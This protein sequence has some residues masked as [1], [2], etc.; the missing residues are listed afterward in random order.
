[1]ADGA[2]IYSTCEENKKGVHIFS[3]KSWAVK[4]HPEEIE[5]T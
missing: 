1:M 5:E 4:L 3:W 2:Y